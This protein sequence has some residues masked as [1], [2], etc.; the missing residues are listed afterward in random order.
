MAAHA[1]L[2]ASGSHTWIPCTASIKACEGIPRKSSV[3]ADEGTLAHDVGE[4]LLLGQPLPEHTDEM[5][6]YVQQYVD[7]CEEL[8]APGS[9]MFVEQRVSFARFV[10]GG[11]F[12]TA[13]CIIVR[14]GRLDIIDLKY[15]Q[16]VQVDA[17]DNPQLRLYAFGALEQLALEYDV[18]TVGMHIVMPRL[19]HISTEVLP[20]AELDSWVEEVVR[21]A[22][23][24][25]YTGEGA[26]FSP[27]EKQCQ[28]CPAQGSCRA[29]L[30][31]YKGALGYRPERDHITEQEIAAVLDQQ[32]AM[33]SWLKDVRAYALE[34]A[35]EGH[36]IPGY[37]VVEARKN[38]VVS[39]SVAELGEAVYTRKLKGLGE[40]E[41]TFGKDVI[42][43]YTSKPEGGPTLAPES[44]KRPDWAA[45]DFEGLC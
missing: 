8:R 30:D 12:G 5:L 27:G 40:L 16:G 42:A 2:S 3:Y 32:A 19:D 41:K 45:K 4:C 21:P 43:P 38:R 36:K 25:A 29:R 10:P 31:V 24:A 11:G 33:E 6:A 13:D 17:Q 39:A 35:L 15:G 28:F 18:E 9:T 23:H 34:L 26:V 7:Y 22:A 37:K 20:A 1:K 44:D 14:K